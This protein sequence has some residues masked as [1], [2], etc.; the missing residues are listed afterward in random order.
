VNIFLGGE[1]WLTIYAEAETEVLTID[2]V[3]WN[4]HALSGLCLH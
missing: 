4:K 1:K 2:I 3:E